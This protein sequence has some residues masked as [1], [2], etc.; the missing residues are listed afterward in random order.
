MVHVRKHNVPA[1]VDIGI[2]F[3]LKVK[4]KKNKSSKKK[5]K[6]KEKFKQSVLLLPGVAENLG[7]SCCPP[8]PLLC[9]QSIA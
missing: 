4:E 3:A 9:R 5:M 1:S 6:E 7:L 2:E 8:L